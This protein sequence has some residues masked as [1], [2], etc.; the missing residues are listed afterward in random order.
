[1][2]RGVMISRLGPRQRSFLQ[3]DFPRRERTILHTTYRLHHIRLSLSETV[4]GTIFALKH[5]K[6]I[7][8]TFNSPCERL[9]EPLRGR[10]ILVCSNF[11]NSIKWCLTCLPRAYFNRSMSAKQKLLIYS[12]VETP[13][14]S[15][16][17]L[18]P[19]PLPCMETSSISYTVDPHPL[20]SCS[21]PFSPST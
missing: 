6:T 8:L 1:M 10:Q 12:M 15:D 9:G 2:D 18:L 4:D 11:N 19:P 5:V 16:F 17:F 21:L 20:N 14:S 7:K 3:T 13:H